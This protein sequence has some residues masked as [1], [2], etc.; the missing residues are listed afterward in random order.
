MDLRAWPVNC[1]E[2]DNLYNTTHGTSASPKELGLN[3][4]EAVTAETGRDMLVRDSSVP[5]GVQQFKPG[6]LIDGRFSVVRFIA[7]GGM[8]EVYE[9]EDGQ[10]RGVHVALKTILSQ[11]ATDPVVLQRFERE[12]LSARAVVHA[13]LCPIYDLGHWKRRRGSLLT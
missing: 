1:R 13:N 4:P 10:L 11:Y 2:M 7:R 12:V 5:A 9:V 6:D 8:G 3:E